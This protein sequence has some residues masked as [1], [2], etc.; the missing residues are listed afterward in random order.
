MGR[1]DGSALSAP[2]AAGFVDDGRGKAA[3]EGKEGDGPRQ[4]GVATGLAHDALPIEAGVT[5]ARERPRRR[6]TAEEELPAR[7]SHGQPVGGPM[8]IW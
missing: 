6:A 5:D 4:A 7:A 8:N 1:A 2:G 3:G